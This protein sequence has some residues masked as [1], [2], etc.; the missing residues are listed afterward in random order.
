VTS[1]GNTNPIIFFDG[2]CNLC[3]G[4]VQFVIRHDKKKSFLFAPLQSAA[5]KQALAEVGATY[6]RVPDSVILLYR[7]Q[8]FVKSAAA[9]QI[10]GLLGGAWPILKMFNAVPLALRDG[11]YGIIARNRYKWFGK[12]DACMIPTPELKARFLA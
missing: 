11:V 6:K 4:F 10:F 7:G 5:G 8:Y 1:H 12:K 2:V 3:N 9:L